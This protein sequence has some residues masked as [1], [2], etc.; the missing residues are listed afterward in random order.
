MDPRYARSRD[1]LRAA[2]YELAAVKPITEVQVQELCE[3]AGVTRD[4]F[5]RHAKSPVELLSSVLAEQLAAFSGVHTDLSG[6]PAPDEP[7]AAA[8]RDLL[9][10]VLDHAAVYRNCMQPGMIAPIREVIE[11][12]VVASLLQHFD[13]H[14][15]ILPSSIEPSREVL[16]MYAKYGA[17]GLVGAIES[18][19]RAPEPDLEQGVAALLATNPAWWFTSP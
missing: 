13:Q 1:R 2:V 3:A 6:G 19:I 8:T 14:P 16:G 4:T 17:G 11:S 12:T 10:Y 18:W 15:E 7:M 9:R 5:Y